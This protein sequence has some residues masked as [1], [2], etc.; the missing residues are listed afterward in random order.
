VDWSGGAEGLTSENGKNKINENELLGEGHQE[1]KKSVYTL[2]W[3]RSEAANLV[4]Y[5][6]VGSTADHRVY[7]GATIRKYRERA[8]MSQEEVAGKADI[9]RNYFG[10]VERGEAYITIKKLLRVAKVGL[11]SPAKQH[12]FWRRLGDLVFCRGSIPLVLAVN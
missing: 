3:Y 10:R 8:G 5:E 2:A 4:G 11:F 1:A 12:K 7:V 9:H 6:F